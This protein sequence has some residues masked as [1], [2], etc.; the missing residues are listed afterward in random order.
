MSSAVSATVPGNGPALTVRPVTYT[1]APAA[2]SSVAMPFPMPRLAPVTTAT[3][4]SRGLLIWAIL[5]RGSFSGRGCTHGRAA[6]WAGG[7]GAVGDT[8]DRRRPDRRA[9]AGVRLPH[10]RHRR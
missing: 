2:P 7:V 4:P 8:P 10:P 1:V 5:E 9:E 3:W 6:R